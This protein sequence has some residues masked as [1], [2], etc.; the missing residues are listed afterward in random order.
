MR[1]TT[2]ALQQSAERGAPLNINP[3]VTL[4]DVLEV[5][6]ERLRRW[7]IYLTGRPDVADDLVQDAVAAAWASHRR[8]EQAE[9]YPAWLAGIARNLCRS[10]R[11]QQERETQRTIGIGE[12]EES[13]SDSKPA[14]LVDPFELEVELERGELAQLLDRALALLPADTRQALIAKYIDESPLTEVAARL[15]ISEGAVAARLHRGKLALRRVLATNLRAEAAAYG[16]A[17][18]NDQTWQQTTIWCPQCGLQR[19][20]GRLASE[21]GAF[22]LRC[23]RCSERGQMDLVHWADRALFAGLSSYRSALSRLSTMGHTYFQAGLRTGEATCVRCKRR[24]LVRLAHADEVPEGAGEPACIVVQCL[25]C[26]TTHFAGL[27]GLLLCHPYAQRFW[28]AHPRLA[29]LPWQRVEVYGR[30]CV[31]ITFHSQRE[32][33][34]LD[35]LADQGTFEV[36]QMDE[37]TTRVI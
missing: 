15:G 35:I 12:M 5:E 16:L 22:L 37:G 20:L 2:P 31:A 9:E 18:E 24:A 11:R 25:F 21:D 3:T 17:C 13:A 4:A 30:P 1:H 29:T 10:W 32:R 26:R 28:H 6:Q 8:P 33:A 23:P 27:T 34:Q 36:L 7:C 14:S 19:L